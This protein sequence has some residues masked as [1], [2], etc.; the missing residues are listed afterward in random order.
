[1]TL[2]NLFGT[3]ISCLASVLLLF[4]CDIHIS[5][6]LLCQR[7]LNQSGDKATRIDDQKCPSRQ[8][9]GVQQFCPLGIK[10]G[11]CTRMLWVQILR[12]H[13]LCFVSTVSEYNPRTF[14]KF[15]LCYLR[16]FISGCPIPYFTTSRNRGFLPFP[17]R[18][19]SRKR[20]YPGIQSR[21][22]S[23]WHLA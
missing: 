12:W 2:N 6:L 14:C 9:I 3:K 5:H 17:S 19:P 11:N 18:F 15:A 7:P 8:P 23:G 4:S 21:V 13:C 16:F 20:T 22:G 10:R 1:M